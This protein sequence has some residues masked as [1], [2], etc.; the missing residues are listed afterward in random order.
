MG[1]RD[2]R[3]IMGQASRFSGLKQYALLLGALSQHFNT[4]SFYGVCLETF[5][6]LHPKIHPCLLSGHL[7]PDR[8]S[9]RSLSYLHFPANQVGAE[10]IHSRMKVTEFDCHPAVTPEYRKIQPTF[11]DAHPTIFQ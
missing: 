4:F 8:L 6:F 11:S 10:L 1:S 7:F 2:D 9:L 3:P 5:P